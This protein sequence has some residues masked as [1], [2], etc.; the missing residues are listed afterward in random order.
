MR[1]PPKQTNNNNNKNYINRKYQMEDKRYEKNVRT[2]VSDF[3]IMWIYALPS[4]PPGKLIGAV[5][6]GKLKE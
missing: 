3:D 6:Q 1:N 2:P 4:E 5:G